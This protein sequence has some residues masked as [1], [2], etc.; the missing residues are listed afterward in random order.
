MIREFEKNILLKINFCDELLKI[1]GKFIKV[2][3]LQ[4]IPKNVYLT[5]FK[6]LGYKFTY[7]VGGYYYNEY[8]VY[9][10][11]RFSL[12]FQIKHN[13]PLAYLVIYLDEKIL[14]TGFN[15]FGWV[16]HYLP[17]NK[18]LINNNFGINSLE[19][20]KEYLNDLIKLFYKFVAQ[21]EK[22]LIDK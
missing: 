8:V 10:N 6:E 3:E 20:M 7:E 5:V 4:I 18:E 11:Y 22:E 16:L 14:D 15:S 17:Y 12:Y 2:R 13:S 19:E 21:Y 9:N 1:R